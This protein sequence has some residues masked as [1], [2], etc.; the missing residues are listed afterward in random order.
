[1]V[2]KNGIHHLNMKMMFDL[3]KLTKTPSIYHEAS[4]TKFTEQAIK[5]RLR[6]CNISYIFLFCQNMYTDPVPDIFSFFI[7]CH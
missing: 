5:A 3:E 1:V 6:E 7:S 2:V 4:N